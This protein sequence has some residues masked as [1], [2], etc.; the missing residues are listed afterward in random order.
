MKKMN[1]N[2]EFFAKEEF[3]TILS[4]I[5]YLPFDVISVD[6]SLKENNITYHL[7]ISTP[8]GEHDAFVTLDKETID[9]NKQNT[10][11]SNFKYKTIKMFVKA[12][13]QEFDRI[14]EDTFS[15]TNEPDI[16]EKIIRTRIIIHARISLLAEM[17][18]NR[19]FIMK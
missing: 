5:P 12:L 13:E 10:N 18:D 1:K 6:A 16:E 14:L 2:H 3:N 4:C 17:L 11:E 8:Y 7:T 15:D 19:E 9:K